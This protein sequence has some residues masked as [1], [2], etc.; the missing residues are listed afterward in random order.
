MAVFLL[1]AK[2][3]GRQKE[4]G[5][6]REG[7]GERE[8]ERG[9]AG[10][11]ALPVP[12]RRDLWWLPAATLSPLIPGSFQPEGH[13]RHKANN[14]MSDFVPFPGARSRGLSTSSCL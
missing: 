14:H 7:K 10:S 13:G 6:G 4:G 8:R 2:V 5:K 3:R 9:A 11:A 12:M 1:G